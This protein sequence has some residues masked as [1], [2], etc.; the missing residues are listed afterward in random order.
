MPPPLSIEESPE[1]SSIRVLSHWFSAAFRPA[2]DRPP[3]VPERPD[4]RERSGERER[5]EDR[6]PRVER[7]RPEDRLP[8][9]RP[10]PRCDRLDEDFRTLDPRF[11]ELP[12]DVLGMFSYGARS[13]RDPAPNRFGRGETPPWLRRGSLGEPR[14]R[15]YPGV[16]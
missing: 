6:E 15:G 5:P 10:P 11:D 12:R 8:P 14:G 4:E 16:P 7:A 9:V 13:S 1:D 3:G 2:V